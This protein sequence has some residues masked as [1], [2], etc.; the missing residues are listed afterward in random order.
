M[1]GKVS[2]ASLNLWCTLLPISVLPPDNHPK[3]GY[4]VLGVQNIGSCVEGLSSCVKI[5]DN[6]LSRIP[7]VLAMAANEA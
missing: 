1:C 5:G 3:M 2:L 6:N 7:T 4:P